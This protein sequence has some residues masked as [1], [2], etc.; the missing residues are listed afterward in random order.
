MIGYL[1]RSR[2]ESGPSS[3]IPSD[4][5]AT[6]HI[7]NVSKGTTTTPASAGGV[8]DTSTMSRR[9]TSSSASSSSDNCVVT[10]S[11]MLGYSSR[12]VLTSGGN[13][14]GISVLTAPTRTLPRISAGPSIIRRSFW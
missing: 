6:K 9:P 2:G 14:V 11:E 8:I 5:L 12:M 4:G 3:G 7:E 13:S 1:A 10:L